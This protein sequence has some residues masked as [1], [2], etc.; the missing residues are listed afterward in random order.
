MVE[1]FPLKNYLTVEL[2]D[3][4]PELQDYSGTLNAKPSEVVYV[5][6]KITF[7][8]KYDNPKDI[9]L[10]KIKE[11]D[12][13]T[14][15]TFVYDVVSR[16]YASLATTPIAYFY[17]KGSRILDL[18]LTAVPYTSALVLSQRYVPPKYILLPPELENLHDIDAL[19][20]AF[21][22]YG[23][24]TAN[25]VPREV[26]RRVLPL[27][28]NSA[29]LLTIPIN[30][31]GILYKYLQFYSD[32]VPW[33]IKET[34]DR[35]ISLVRKEDPTILDAVL[36]SPEFNINVTGRS[37]FKPQDSI[38]FSN[39]EG[40]IGEYLDKRAYTLIES[41]RKEQERIF[42][43]P[44]ETIKEAVKN[45]W[46]LSNIVIPYRSYYTVIIQWLVSI[47][48]YNELKR[49]RTIEIRVE[50]IY[51]AIKNTLE[52]RRDLYIPNV[53]EINKNYLEKYVKLSHEMLS[54]YQ[55]L[56]NQGIPSSEAIYVIPH[57]IK[58][59]VEV[60]L[61]L[62]QLLTPNLFYGIRSCMTAEFEMRDK[63]WGIPKTILRES[64]YPAF[65]KK[66]YN[67]LVYRNRD[68][69]VPLS[70]CRI[71]MCPEPKGRNCRIIN[72]FIPQYDH[73]KFEEERKS[74][75]N[76]R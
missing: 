43:N 67:L 74:Y 66:L 5:G 52:G 72:Q 59:G 30:V 60:V 45:S 64:K 29:M 38:E 13:K 57:N 28:S 1:I 54:L 19:V 22:F 18:F 35:M 47:A 53:I 40:I 31:L 55:N 73:K 49:H 14:I 46:K 51:S 39:R 24:L 61:T 25:N 10:K 34:V 3:L 69:E 17:L 33:E 37:L 48:M 2:L 44:P 63:V 56:V 76:L 16:G 9:L 26:A 6:S 75:L 15:K 41:Y 21:E 11:G 65:A 36:N 42:K 27:S 20:K 71:G 50:S 12:N 58:V 4:T 23:Q 8:S 70:K 68:L 62:D 32:T 7:S